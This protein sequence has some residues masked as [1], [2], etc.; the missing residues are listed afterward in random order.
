MFNDITELEKRL[1][2]KG[3][4]SELIKMV[5][6]YDRI[7]RVF[8]NYEINLKFIEISPNMENLTTDK[9]SFD[10]SNFFINIDS[11]EYL[12]FLINDKLESLT[13]DDL[14]R[15]NEIFRRQSNKTGIFIVYNDEE[16]N[17][18]LLLSDEIYSI[19]RNLPRALEIIKK[20][21]IPLKNIIAD[22]LTEPDYKLEKLNLKK[23]KQDDIFDT[24]H[25]N[26]EFIIKDKI[27]R[28]RDEEKMKFLTEFDSKKISKLLS[29]IEEYFE[30]NIGKDELK[31]IYKD[32]V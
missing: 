23:Y 31:Q 26:L 6:F 8:K 28:V 5:L 13:K 32:L 24:L 30:E 4:K 21:Y 18:S 1:K 3:D 12:M 22:L 29:V 14:E 27:K 11:N 17:S 2:N 10:F 15:Y 16:L 7:L 19:R 20:K 25:K 9:Y